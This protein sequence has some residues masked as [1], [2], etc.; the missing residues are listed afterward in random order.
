MAE[1][2]DSATRP[3][4]GVPPLAGADRAEARLSEVHALL[5][6][7]RNVS[8][9]NQILPPVFS[10]AVDDRLVQVRLGVASS[11][12]TA[13]QC[14]HAATAGHALRVALNCSAWATTMQFDA[15]HRDAIETA[16]LLH[17]IGVIGVPDRILLK[18]GRLNREEQAAV[19]RS[20]HLSL[21]ILRHSCSDRQI[22]DVVEHVP[23]WFDGSRKGFRLA[24]EELPLGARMIA[25]AEAF[26]A[27]TTDHVYRP[28][29][30]HERAMAELYHCAGSQFDPQLVTAF[31][32]FLEQNPAQLQAEVADRWLRN[33]D[34]GLANS[35]WSLNCVPSLAPR[36][37]VD[38]LFQAKLLDNMYDAVVFIDANVRIS[39]WNRGAE[40]LTGIA[41]SSLLQR[42]WHP[43]LLDMADE[44]GNL[45]VEADC[46]VHSAV[47]SG[48]QSLRRL[49]IRGRSGQA[50]AVDAHTFPVMEDDGTIL[51]VVLQFHDASS[52]TSL[53]QR[54]QS[55]HEKATKDPL[56]Q[57]ANRAE[58]DRVHEMFIAAHR[59]QQIP[60]SLMI[61]DLDRFK[62]VNDTYGHQAGDDVIKSL[63]SLLKKFCRP[64]DLAARYGG[65]EFVVLCADCD[66][67]AAAR[68]ADQIR[69]ALGNLAQPRM[70]GRAATVSFGV[71]EVQ[72]GDTAE[73]MLRR[74]DRALLMAKNRGRNNVMQLGTG[75]GVE[76]PTKG[77]ASFWTRKPTAAG[78]LL[79]KT[80]VTPVPEKMAIE[81]LRGFVAD[82]QAKV[83]H[84]DGGKVRIEIDDI[85]S[86][87]MR[88]FTDRPVSFR[89]DLQFVEDRQQGKEGTSVDRVVQ[90]RIQVSV[91]LRKRRDRRR[92]DLTERARQ[93]F[94][95]LKSYLMAAE[96]DAQSNAKKGSRAKRILTPW[97]GRK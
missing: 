32:E 67:A 62:L 90:T 23:A 59:Q 97:L 77:L 57:V 61:C 78:A 19:S 1:H 16:A 73:T 36:P 8:S 70:N 66:N 41:E 25:L 9:T 38:V 43:E 64:G 42:Q 35:C 95:S 44:R 65:E 22:L 55:L 68:R 84:V 40:R 63:A 10:T 50:M 85:Q 37:R 3:E 5:D 21:K 49:T 31:A 58:F 47:R 14:K 11:L 72:P 7:L 4:T 54:C 93:V 48:V 92:T 91:S 34:S 20:R 51:G 74:A 76:E 86:G 89:L 12:F 53:E 75:A 71:T 30:S 26:D 27:M 87:M 60:C 13:L 56:T 80:L 69:L 39:L 82:H 24:G 2:S 46:P 6:E 88:R 17:D 18:P 45:V 28:A 83:I 94:A 15:E 52:E 96:D 33:L 29:M 81:K 79:E